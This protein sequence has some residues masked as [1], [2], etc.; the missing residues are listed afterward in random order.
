MQKYTVNKLLFSDGPVVMVHVTRK[1]DG[2][3]LAM[4]VQNFANRTQADERMEEVWRLAGF[5]HKNLMPTIEVF[6]SV[7]DLNECRQHVVMPYY[8]TTLETLI[9]EKAGEGLPKEM[10]AQMLKNIGEALSHMH[11]KGKVHKEVVPLNIFKRDGKSSPEFVL[12]DRG[13][14]EDVKSN[15]GI[16]GRDYIPPELRQGGK[17]NQTNL[18]GKIDLWAL[19]V[20]ASRAVVTEGQWER[21]C[22][23]MRHNHVRAVAF[24]GDMLQDKI[25]T[26]LAAVVLQLL[27]QDPV[28]RPDARTFLEALRKATADPAI[29]FVKMHRDGILV[30]AN[31][32]WYHC[33][34]YKL[35]SMLMS[36]LEEA[37]AADPRVVGFYYHNPRSEGGLMYDYEKIKGEAW[38]ITDPVLTR[39]GGFITWSSSNRGWNGTG[40]PSNKTT[41]EV[42]KGWETWTAHKREAA[43][44]L[45]PEV[46]AFSDLLCSR[47]EGR[48]AQDPE[49]DSI[50]ELMDSLK[51]DAE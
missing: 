34:Q 11:G 14:P 48:N 38:P 18:T 23:R 46:V 27:Q 39:C 51:H 44:V 36:N 47:N 25:G 43:I 45:T 22:R 31:N 13:L 16:L 20:A 7:S 32:Q 15:E 33:V 50:Y 9:Q 12:G 17:K 24:L 4:K 5:S 8:T 2:Q 37:A 10:V 1:K 42:G 29:K 28:R 26:T 30:D 41:T 40:P 35:N 3:D 19:G 6:S 49:I 21:I